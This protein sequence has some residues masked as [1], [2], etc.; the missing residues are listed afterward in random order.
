[1]VIETYVIFVTRSTRS[2]PKITS[3]ISWH[4]M[5][6]DLGKN[7]TSMELI[8]FS[9]LI[10]VFDATDIHWSPTATSL[11]EVAASEAQPRI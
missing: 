1:M 2:P 6:M 11:I 4:L 10:G 9:W 8:Y 7:F 5:H 3:D